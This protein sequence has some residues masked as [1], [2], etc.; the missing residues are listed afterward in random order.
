MA[1]K[2]HVKASRPLAWVLISVLVLSTLVSCASETPGVTSEA[3]ST[4]AAQSEE[5]AAET[6]EPAADAVEQPAEGPAAR[7]GMYSEPPTMQI[8][9]EKYYV[10]T[11]ETEKGDIALELFAD[12]VP[13]TVNNF[14]FLAREGFYD[15]TTFHRV[16]PGFMAQGGD[17]TGTGMGGPGYTFADEFDP[18]L[19]HDRVGLLSMANAGPGTNG[20]QFFITFAPTPWLDGQHT[21]FGKIIAG[22]EILGLLSER[23]PQTATVPGDLIKTIR[24]T[25]SEEPI[26]SEIPANDAVAV[27][28]A[29][30][31]RNNL[32]LQPPVMQID[33]EVSYVATIFTGKGEIV[34]S[35]DAEAAPLTVNNF[36]SLARQGFYDGLTFHRVEPG[37]VIQGGDPLGSGQG[38]PGYLI[39]AEIG[40]PHVEGAIAMARLGD[41]GNPRQMSSGSQF[42]ITLAETAMLDGAYT[43]FGQVTD[44]MDV[45]TAIAVG[46]T[47][48]RI[49]IAEQQ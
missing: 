25:E 34:L 27:P 6:A 28:D 21:V 45:V 32:Y 42:Y 35:L 47:I 16:I 30:A 26:V 46:D 17:P 49:D 13:V 43:V 12:K 22:V 36:V 2:M 31:A 15:E 39:P 7:E 24:I 9:P 4:E 23:D 37:F 8:D 14:V 3:V 10:A 19:N 44:G 20:S 1:K 29:P 33:P 11:I 41:Q 38:G 18:A 5:L 40:L 48:E